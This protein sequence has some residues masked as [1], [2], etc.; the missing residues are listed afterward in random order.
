MGTVIHWALYQLCKL[1]Y[2]LEA[3]VK[4]DGRHTAFI[5]CPQKP[6]RYSVYRTF[7]LKINILSRGSVIRVWCVICLV[8]FF[9]G[10]G[11]HFLGS[12]S[13]TS[14]YINTVSK[15]KG[16]HNH[17]Y[18]VEAHQPVQISLLQM[19]WESEYSPVEEPCLRNRR[20]RY[21]GFAAPRGGI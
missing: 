3:K 4:E 5:F 6:H 19:Y 7:T 2:F 8:L 16:W 17:R 10:G 20:N 21:R 14:S 15:Y 11:W 18:S 13:R 1:K 12:E 9:L